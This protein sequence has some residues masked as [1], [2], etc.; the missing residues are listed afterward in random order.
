MNYRHGDAVGGVIS[1]EYISWWEMKRRC[2]QRHRHNYLYYGGRGIRV[3]KR[4]LNS[5]KNFLDDMGR[6]PSRLYTLDRINNSGNYTPANC[7][8]A[9]KKEQCVTRRKKGTAL[10]YFNRSK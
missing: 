10:K 8:W 5:F 4:W 3:C 2:Y 9:D 6:K 1:S 7:K